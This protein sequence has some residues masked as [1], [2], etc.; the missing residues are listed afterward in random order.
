MRSSGTKFPMTLPVN[1]FGNADRILEGRGQGL[2]FA[3]DHRKDS[4]GHGPD[5]N[6]LIAAVVAPLPS[7]ILIEDS[8]ATLTALARPI[9]LFENCLGQRH[10]LRRGIQTPSRSM[11]RRILLPWLFRCTYHTKRSIAASPNRRQRH[12]PRPTG[13][14]KPRQGE[15]DHPDRLG[16]EKQSNRLVPEVLHHVARSRPPG[17]RRRPDERRTPGRRLPNRRTTPPSGKT[18][19][20]RD[21][22]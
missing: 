6:S 3:E 14:G 9:F 13:I 12:R 10:Q 5:Q 19:S 20:V 17:G 16:K 4:G 21:R 7:I 2:Q 22:Q 1:R 11:S 15:K 8:G 18:R